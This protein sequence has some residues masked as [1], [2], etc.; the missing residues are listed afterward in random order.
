MCDIRD[1]G[2]TVYISSQRESVRWA[3]GVHGLSVL[4]MYS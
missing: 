3:N 4:E 2:T 1:G